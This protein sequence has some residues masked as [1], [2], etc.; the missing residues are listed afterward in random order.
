MECLFGKIENNE[1]ILNDAGIMINK[2]WEKIPEKFPDIELGVYQTMPNHFHAIAIN[3]GIGVGANPRVRPLHNDEIIHSET[4][5]TPNETGQT[6]GSAPTDNNNPD[7]ILGE[8]M[9]SPLHR[10]AQ[11]F[12]TMSTNE[13]I[14]GVKTLGWQPFDGKIW[15]RNYYE[16]IIRNEKSYQRISEYIINNPA[17]WNDD[18]FYTK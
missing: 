18:K 1:M 14:R 10:I 11:W 12:K 16:H 5:Q 2:W 3:T 17:K 9:G 13:Y 7:P 4:G 15:Q 6:R 8:H